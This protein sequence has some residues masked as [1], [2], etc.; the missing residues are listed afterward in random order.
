MSEIIIVF[1][2][3]LFGLCVLG[4]I[5]VLI[6]ALRKYDDDIDYDRIISELEEQEK[7]F[8]YNK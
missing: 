7:K 4:G 8:R 5:T 2:I 3:L 6:F 1:Q